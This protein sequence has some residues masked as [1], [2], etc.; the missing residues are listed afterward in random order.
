M[1]DYLLVDQPDS[2]TE[3]ITGHGQLGVDTEFV[4]EKTY[5]AQLCLVQVSTPEQIYCVDPLTDNSQNK[6]WL[7]MLASSWVVHSARQDIEVVLQTAGAMPREIFDTQ[8]AAGLLGFPAQMGYAGLVKELFDVDM[9]KTHTRADWTR[10]PLPEAFLQYAAE[11]VEYLLPAGEALA[12]RLDKE[13]RL[14]WAKED[15]MLL[16]DPALYEVV[17]NQAIERL[18]GARNFRGQKRAAAV[19]LARWRES[20]AMRRNR[21]RQWI[22]RDSVLL[23]VAYNLPT[24][25]N[26]LASIAGLPSKLAKRIGKQLLDEVAAS[27]GDDDD[28]QPPK[29]PDE[30]QKALLKEMQAQVAACAND[31]GLAAETVAPKRELSAVIAS[32]TRESRVFSGWRGTLIGEQL[33]ALL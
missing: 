30:A 7:E 24:S 14:D 28:Y 9:A 1:P 32:G 11:D 27:S 6:F 15:S 29:P 20:E 10:R 19:R 5:F 33:M 12:E 16:L 23:D 25:E 31:L 8:V 3:N 26:Q 22:L 13:S 17:G 2:I 4:R 21:P 18:K